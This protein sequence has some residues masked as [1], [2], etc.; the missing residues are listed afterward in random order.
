MTAHTQTDDKCQRHATTTWST[1]ATTTRLRTT[2]QEQAGEWMTLLRARHILSY[3]GIRMQPQL[4][5]VRALAWE[6]R[7]G[8]LDCYA[9]GNIWPITRGLQRRRPLRAV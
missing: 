6:H 7:P 9:T 4:L 3:V 8:L 1:A 2:G 5:H